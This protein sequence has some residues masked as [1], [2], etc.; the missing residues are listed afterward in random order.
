MLFLLVRALPFLSPLIYFLLMRGLMVFSGWWYVWLVVIIVLNFATFYLFLWKRRRK[1]V[2]F[3]FIYST[4]FLCLGFAQSLLFSTG[5]VILTL[6]IIW[7]VIYAIYLESIFNYLYRTKKFFLIELKSITA[8]INLIIIFFLGLALLGFYIFLNVSWWWIL[9][10]YFVV[11]FIILFDR[12]LIH[13]FPL[14]VNVVYSAVI[15]L[16]LIEILGGLL[17]W[18]VSMYVT[19]IILSI[20][21]YIASS[22]AILEAQDRLDKKMI[23][24]FSVFALIALVI[25]LGTAQWS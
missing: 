18:P 3:F 2:W 9:L 25:V 8:Y 20:I 1:R 13:Q 19:S 15:A 10:I 22:Y 11:S 16:I 23:I 21:Y 6:Q 4:I 7:S 5:A 12:F 17:W 14:S 24:R